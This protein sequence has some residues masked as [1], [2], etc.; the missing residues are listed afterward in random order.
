[1]LM[2][3]Q[4]RRATVRLWR[5]WHLHE[6]IRCTFSCF[7]CQSWEHLCALPLWPPAPGQISQDEILLH[8]SLIL[9]HCCGRALYCLFGS[10]ISKVQVLMHN[11]AF[12]DLVYCTVMVSLRWLAGR[13]RHAEMKMYP[14]DFGRNAYHS[15]KEAVLL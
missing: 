6:T 5:D 15:L 13:G 2:Q 7:E 12:E 4:S 11:T 10:P 9:G 14:S 8:E 3:M 1:M